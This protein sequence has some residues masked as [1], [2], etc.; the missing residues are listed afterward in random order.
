MSGK[1]VRLMRNLN[2]KI[3]AIPMI[4]T[5]LVVFVGGTIW[6]VVYSFTDSKLLPRLNWAGLEQYERLWGTSRW[7]ISIENLVF[8]GIMS[9][10]FT[11]CMG[12]L[13]AVL[14]DQKIRFE[15][16]PSA[17]RRA[18]LKISSSL[19]RLAKLVGEGGQ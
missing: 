17:A 5:T 3:A 19:L 7:L 8:Y 15:I 10:I 16:N 18:G 2:A 13:L 4:L 12:F 1:P 14:M 6:T 9:M 11:I